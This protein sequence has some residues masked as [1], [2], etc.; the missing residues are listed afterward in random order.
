MI[1]AGQGRVRLDT[2]HF[3]EDEFK[4]FAIKHGILLGD[5]KDI[6]EMAVD[7]T[8]PPKAFYHKAGR[9]PVEHDPRMMREGA[10]KVWEKFATAAKKDSRK[11]SEQIQPPHKSHNEEHREPA[12]THNVDPRTVPMTRV[13]Q[14][15]TNEI[16][17][18]GRMIRLE[19]SMKQMKESQE[20]LEKSTSM[21]QEKISNMKKA[22]KTA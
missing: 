8:R 5:T 12:N 19:H 10:R 21:C 14:S 15:T 18:K 6:P 16:M 20:L 17:Q 22:Q 4:T 3:S 7:L 9:E 13:E 11:T 2:T 1:L